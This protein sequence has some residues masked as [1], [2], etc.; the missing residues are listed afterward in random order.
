MK[1]ILRNKKGFVLVTAL[2]VMTLLLALGGAAITMSQLGYTSIS[3][4]KRYQLATWAADYA[5]MQGVKDIIEG[6]ATTNVCP[7][8]PVTGT[9]GSGAS[10]AYYSYFGIRDNSNTYCFLKAEGK[11]DANTASV[12]KT[13]LVPIAGSDWGA[14]VTKGGSI[15][16]GGSGAIAGCDDDEGSCN[17]RCGVLPGVITAPGAL[18]Y[19]GASNTTQS[20]GSEGSLRGIVGNPP[21]LDEPKLSNPNYDFVEKYL[22]V[23]LTTTNGQNIPSPTN[24]FVSVPSSSSMT[25]WEKFMYSLEYALDMPDIFPNICSLF[26]PIPANPQYCPAGTN[27][28]SGAIGHYINRIKDGTVSA[29]DTL[30]T[31]LSQSTTTSCRFDGSSGASPKL[32]A[33]SSHCYI[34]NTEIR[35]F[36]SST[37]NPCATTA[38]T[39]INIGTGQCGRAGNPVYLRFAV[40]PTIYINYSAE[41]AEKKHILIDVDQDPSNPPNQFIP[42]LQILR[43][44]DVAT[45]VDP[46]TP[47]QSNLY[48]SFTRTV[49]SNI[50]AS[51]LPAGVIKQKAPHIIINNPAGQQPSPYSNVAINAQVINPSNNQLER[52]HLI[53]SGNIYFNTSNRMDIRNSKFVS[54][55][56]IALGEPG[57]NSRWSE[58]LTDT[59]FFSRNLY[60]NL[61][62]RV[63]VRGGVFYSY[64][65][66]VFD[67]QGSLNFGTGPDS[68]TNFCSSGSAPSY[69]GNNGKPVLIIA[70]DPRNTVS[71]GTS[72]SMPGNLSLNGMI[73]TT[74]S[75]VSI[76]G[77]VAIQGTIINTNPTTAITNTGNSVIQFNKTILDRLFSNLSVCG[78]NL[79]K[80]PKCGAGNKRAYVSN[81]KVTLY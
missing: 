6:T 67:T 32:G 54:G 64:G 36:G 27:P 29:P 76:T 8:A 15:S 62:S 13:V 38:N 19:S 70:G 41:F 21:R 61:E 3:A 48:L 39:T 44:P 71:G 46:T 49:D 16:L 77:S 2:A 11:K 40:A 28:M 30:F 9:I 26:S 80:Q 59:H 73:Y 52:I 51:H 68:S 18:S 47:W 74:A 55:G 63:E 34:C 10:T 57:S 81:T 12:V 45:C 20:C 37:A 79:V 56:D 24:E 43:T 69:T 22:N 65:N 75:T 5:L 53:T 7:S 42:N 35:C 4:E 50:V 17:N 33:G 78:I 1:N 66:M 60:F 23:S 25:S 72:L 58:Y 31:G 14:I